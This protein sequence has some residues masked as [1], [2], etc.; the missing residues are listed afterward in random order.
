LT[1]RASV[2]PGV[3]RTTRSWRGILSFTHL[4]RR[5]RM[6]VIIG[7]R[8]LLARRRRGRMAARG[9]RAAGGNASD[10]VPG[11]HFATAWAPYLT[12]FKQGLREAG[13]IEGQNVTIEVSVGG[14]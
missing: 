9:A 10:R 6:T 1:E 4:A 14:R 11:Q 12:A 5:V 3:V 8:E 7:R 2:R 13:Y